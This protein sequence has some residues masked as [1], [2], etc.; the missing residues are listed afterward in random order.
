MPLLE[1]VVGSSRLL[2]L[3]GVPY[4]REKQWV[5]S[6]AVEEAM[7]V[8]PNDDGDDVEDDSDDRSSSDRDQSPPPSPTMA[9]SPKSDRRPASLVSKRKN[10]KTGAAKKLP[11]RSSKR[12]RRR[13]AAD[14]H[15]ARMIRHPLTTTFVPSSSKTLC[16]E[17]GFQEAAWN[18][19]V[20]REL[21]G[22]PPSRCSSPLSSG[23]ECLM[24]EEKDGF[25]EPSKVPMRQRGTDDTSYGE[26]ESDI[27][28]HGMSSRRKIP[29]KYLLVGGPYRWE[30]QE[31][32]FLGKPWTPSSMQRAATVVMEK[33]NGEVIGGTTGSGSFR[34]HNHIPVNFRSEVF[35]NV[36]LL[37]DDHQEKAI[38]VTCEE[39][40]KRQV[41]AI[42]DAL[43]EEMQMNA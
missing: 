34:V 25:K 3:E 39:K 16:G 15:M 30:I 23:I 11:V 36:K 37:Q 26:S 12:V 18:L 13:Q 38:F 43:H 19:D 8:V 7:D 27:S 24:I 9:R 32:M 1:G 2:A 20:T 4:Q 17:L 22:R 14:E 41:F 6:N 42:L 5:I 35:L 28:V 21:D 31:S 10:T 33:E 29:G 40:L